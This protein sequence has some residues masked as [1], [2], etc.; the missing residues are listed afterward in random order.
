MKAERQRANEAVWRIGPRRHG[1][2]MRGDMQ[3]GVADRDHYAR[4]AGCLTGSTTTTGKDRTAHTGLATH[5]P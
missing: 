2:E 5:H 4:A 1:R 3:T